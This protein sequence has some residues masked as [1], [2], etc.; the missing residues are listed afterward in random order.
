MS[1]E[2]QDVEIPEAKLVRD[3]LEALGSKGAPP[4]DG[5][6]PV[7]LFAELRGHITWQTIVCGAIVAVI[8]GCSYPYMVLKLG[9]GPNI[10]VVSP[11]ITRSRYGA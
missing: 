8:M 10:A 11:R 1:H 2:D 4:D 9:F 7:S 6:K 5:A 3:E